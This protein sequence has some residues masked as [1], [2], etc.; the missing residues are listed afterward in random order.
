[1]H[2]D[3]I[4]ALHK[5]IRGSNVDAS[6]FYLVKLLDSGDLIS[7]CRRLLCLAN[8]DIGLANPQ[9][10]W[11]AK[12]AIDTALMLGLPEGRLPLSNLTILLASS[13]KSNS[14]LSIDLALK[15]V[16]LGKGI[17]IPRIV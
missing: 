11:I 6:L 15:D 3:F 10:I 12:N 14:A 16:R 7:A 5:L 1:M 9:V 17:D 2:Y 4:S 8:E 13:P